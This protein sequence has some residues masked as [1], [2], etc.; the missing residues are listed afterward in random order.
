MAIMATV[1]MAAG[2]LGGGGTAMA[3]G[4]T[5]PTIGTTPNYKAFPSMPD[6]ATTSRDYYSG[7]WWAKSSSGTHHIQAHGGQMVPVTENGQRVWYWYGESHE[8][9]YG[10]S[11]GIHVYRSTDL[12]NWTDMGM[13]LRAI[14]QPSQVNDPYFRSLYGAR[15]NDVIPYLNTNGDWNHD[16]RADHLTAI[17]ERPKVLHN[18]R[19]GKWVMWFHSDGQTSL[20]GSNYS[21]ALLGVAIADRPTGPFKFIGAYK[22]VNDNT[23][24]AGGWGQ[25][26]DARDMTAYAA[27]DGNAYVGY[28]SEGNTTTYVA[29]LD[30]SWTHLFSTT[31]VDKN[32]KPQSLKN[33][34]QYSWDD[35]YTNIL[36]GRR[37]RD[38]QI[39]ANQ[40]REAVSFLQ[41]GGRTYAITSAT[42]GWSPNAQNWYV[43]N[44]GIL[45]VYGSGHRL[46]RGI[47][48][49]EGKADVR[50]N[51]Y[52]SQVASII[53]YDAARGRFI[54][55]GDRWDAG[56]ADSGYVI[57]PLIIRA[58][59]DLS[60][61]N[62]GSWSLDY[63]D[64][65]AGAV[66]LP[67][68]RSGRRSDWNS[69]DM[70]WID[71]SNLPLKSGTRPVSVTMP[72]GGTMSANLTLSIKG[73]SRMY[74]ADY[75]HGAG[76]VSSR[77]FAA[78][79]LTGRLALGLRPAD[80]NKGAANAD[81]WMRVELTD[82]TMS[83][84]SASGW[85]MAM[86]DAESMGGDAHAYEELDFMTHEPHRQGP[87]W[88]RGNGSRAYRVA[89]SD[90]RWTMRLA[91]GDPHGGESKDAALAF[92]WKP[93]H[94]R[95][96]MRQYH[97]NGNV[98][99]AIGLTR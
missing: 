57:L 5:L 82:I 95:A 97:M 62:P 65:L 22:G 44:G 49:V 46:T 88:I 53:P 30:P 45:G 28:S 43:T 13:A 35:R 6:V 36:S 14:N 73:D 91:G 87:S 10:N 66:T 89:K 76:P 33:T 27:N 55:L 1:A 61:A 63:W 64:R 16:G 37:G 83:G 67:C 78:Y 51:T 20:G 4:N 59:G 81:R 68:V 7:R 72:D 15:L 90:D 29:R 74:S 85:H 70:C 40:R 47:D 98:A 39:V 86:A 94:V 18:P 99:L 19:T 56:G 26:G 60:M 92:V 11:P 69:G 58:N 42:T 50:N 3:D 75:S 80:Y 31:W 21:R 34:W 9:G 38:W 2:L 77:L 8:H 93:T 24:N 71:W 48:S 17:M 12:Y 32:R 52:G 23:D 96:L 41:Y 84:P 25:L 54:Y 79:G